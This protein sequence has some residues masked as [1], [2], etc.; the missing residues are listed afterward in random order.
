M[1]FNWDLTYQPV[2]TLFQDKNINYTDGIKVDE[3]TNLSDSYDASNRL[4]AAYAGINLPFEKLKIYTR[5]AEWRKTG[6]HSTDLMKTDH[7]WRL[8][9]IILD[10][11]P[12]LNMS[13]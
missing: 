6:N 12:S 4:Y 2:D 11:F 5:T 10:F 3:S 9:M 7:R 1:T 8:T 13:L